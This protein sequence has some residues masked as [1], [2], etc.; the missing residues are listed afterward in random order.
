MKPGDL[1]RYR[2]SPHGGGFGMVL[3]I[4]EEEGNTNADVLWNTGEL[5]LISYHPD[6]LEVISETW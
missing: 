1:I 4:N 3:E 6:F 5:L 2:Y